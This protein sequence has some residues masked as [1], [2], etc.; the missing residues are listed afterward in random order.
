[1]EICLPL[2]SHVVLIT[3]RCIR[4][5]PTTV[6]LCYRIYLKFV[7][8]LGFER[9][10]V[11]RHF[12]PLVHKTVAENRDSLPVVD[13]LPIGKQKAGGFL[14]VAIYDAKKL[15]FPFGYCV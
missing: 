7:Q 6:A 8:G 12:T 5:A 13:T 14:I 1:M 9:Q 3:L 2:R 4:V 11:G 10:I 15:V